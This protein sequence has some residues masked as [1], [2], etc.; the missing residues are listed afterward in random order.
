MTT[1]WHRLATVF[2]TL[3]GCGGGN[4][5]EQVAQPE[6]M[7]AKEALNERQ[8]GDSS[9]LKVG[10]R[11]TPLIVDVKASERADLEE[12]MGR[13]VGIVGYDCNRIKLLHDCRLPGDYGFVGVSLKKEAVQLASADEVKANLPFSASLL[14]EAGYGRQSSLDLATIMIGK[15][16]TSV[17]QAALGEATGTCQGATHF[18][19]GAYVG[20]FAMRTGTIGKVESAATILGMGGSLKSDSSKNVDNRDGDPAR[21]EQAS[22]DA[23]APPNGCAALLRLELI[24]LSPEKAK[25]AAA[26][27]P[28]EEP[29]TCPAGTVRAGGMCTKDTARPHVCLPDDVADC[30]AQCDRGD[31]ESCAN[32]AVQRLKSG[33]DVPGAV[34]LLEKACAAGAAKGCNGLGVVAAKGMQGGVDFAAAMTHYLRACELGYMRACYNVAWSHHQGQGVPRDA[35]KAEPLYRRACDG[36]EGLACMNL[37][38]VIAEKAGAA[39]E[40]AQAVKLFERACYGGEA[41]GCANLAV[42]YSKGDGVGKDEAKAK[43]LAARAC[44]EGHQPSC[45][46]VGRGPG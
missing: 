6:A 1:R 17:R 31:R 46:A 21:C 19:R 42:A 13:G 20:A 15:R 45:G 12:A 4:L 43:E 23:K 3:V 24:A 10:A 22:P 27:Q 7:T 41:Q 39:R 28:P 14:V 44:R 34:K 9:C 26:E 38:V 40:M 36:G 25:P 33:Q 11:D 16:T 2:A 29:A 35:S 30:T 5:A 8:S 18:I 37:G 32:L